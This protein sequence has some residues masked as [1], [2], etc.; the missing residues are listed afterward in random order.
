M[1]A[2]RTERLAEKAVKLRKEA[3]AIESGVA[4]ALE[5]AESLLEQYRQALQAAERFVAADAAL[6]HRPRKPEDAH[7]YAWVYVDGTPFTY[8]EH[9]R[10]LETVDAAR[11]KITE[12][13]AVLRG[14]S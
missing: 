9:E 12:K 13:L 2:D 8:A 11:K 7:R 3:A 1:T 4:E 5:K 10:R 14:E 6:E